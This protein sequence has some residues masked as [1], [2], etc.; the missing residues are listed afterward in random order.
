[1]L[2]LSSSAICTLGVLQ[3]HARF[4][5][6]PIDELSFCFNMVPVY[7]DQAEVCEAL[8]S[9]PSNARLVMDEEV[10]EERG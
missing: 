4:Y 1:M 5:K 3:N 8:E 9:L 10:R 6:L 7:R 2:L